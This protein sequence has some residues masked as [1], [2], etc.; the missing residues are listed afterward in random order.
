MKENLINE[1]CH[2]VCISDHTTLIVNRFVQ[3]RLNERKT[4][5]PLLLK[6]RCRTY[7]HDADHTRQNVY[8]TRHKTV[9]Q[10]M[11][12]QALA[13]IK[14]ISLRYYISEQKKTVFF[15][16]KRQATSEQQVSVGD[17]RPHFSSIGC[18]QVVY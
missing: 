16:I 17:T 11:T 14:V 10:M 9:V 5:I 8:A 13:A 3:E 7:H 15:P 18:R 12:S 1:R 6:H 2:I 4:H